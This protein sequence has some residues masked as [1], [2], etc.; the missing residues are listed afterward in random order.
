MR[1]RPGCRGGLQGIN[2][3]RPAIDFCAE[4]SPPEDE[5]EDKI[6]QSGLKLWSDSAVLWL[7]ETG[8]WYQA[9]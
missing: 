3:E 6:N 2:P 5:L 8:S 1:G 4:G 7:N 9:L